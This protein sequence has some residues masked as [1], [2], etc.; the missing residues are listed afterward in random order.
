MGGGTSG[1]QMIMIHRTF[2][3][4]VQAVRRNSRWTVL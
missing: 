3:S 4:R 1:I 2:M